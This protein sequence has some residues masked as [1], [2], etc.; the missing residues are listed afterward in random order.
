[1]VQNAGTKH[2][3]PHH[4]LRSRSR[5]SCPAASRKQVRPRRRDGRRCRVAAASAGAT[6]ASVLSLAQVHRGIAPVHTASATRIAATTSASE[7]DHDTGPL[8][9]GSLFN[10]VL[11]NNVLLAAKRTSAAPRPHPAASRHSSHTRLGSA[12]HLSHNRLVKR[13]ST[14]TTYPAGRAPRHLVVSLRFTPDKVWERKWRSQ[15]TP[16]EAACGNGLWSE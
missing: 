5:C 7:A 2:R 12:S 1:M 6:S 9:L 3:V 16:R 11:A 4:S 15:G 14:Q 13:R 10:S 8:R